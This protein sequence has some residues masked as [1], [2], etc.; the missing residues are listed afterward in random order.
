MH[1]G[2]YLGAV[3]NWVNMQEYPDTER[4][5]CVVDLHSLTTNY[6]SDKDSKD[7]IES[8][9]QTLKT[10]A[11]LIACGVDPKKSNLFIQSHV[12][13]HSE[14]SWILMCMTPMSW[15]NSMIQYK[16]KRKKED[17]TSVALLNYPCLMAADIILYQPSMVPVGDDQRQHLELTKLLIQ[18]INALSGLELRVPDVIK[19]EHQRVMSLKNASNKMSK[20]D[21]SIRSRISLI[22]DPEMIKEKIRRA[23]TDSLG[24]I[25]YDPNRKELYNLLNIYASVK[26]IPA[27][28]LEDYLADDNMF[29]FKMKLADG[30]IDKICPIGERYQAL[31]QEEDRLLEILE[32]GAKGANLK[33][34]KTLATIRK[35]LK[36]LPRD[37]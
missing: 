30:L 11:N 6:V 36:M 19:S 34:D 22:D 16:E 29:S 14:L 12:P 27:S 28:N 3:K 13:A 18:R 4:Y 32:Q 17:S 20:S 7:Q 5:Y 37:M 21:R 24:S 31:L 26:D 23:K 35:G 25:T 33:A 10:A 1:L 15:L 2:N 8:Q 9:E